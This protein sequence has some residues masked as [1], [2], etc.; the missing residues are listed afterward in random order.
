MG[1]DIMDVQNL[2]LYHFSTWESFSLIASFTMSSHINY[3]FTNSLNRL[4]AL[5]TV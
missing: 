2:F 4:S 1:A 5:M 3:A